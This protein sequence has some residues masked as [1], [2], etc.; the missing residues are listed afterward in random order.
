MPLPDW[1]L[2]AQERDNPDS[3]IPTW[4][5]GNA[6][7]PLIHGKAYFDRLVTEVE[8]LQEGDHLFFTDWRGD[9]DERM[10]DDGPTIV[11]LFGAAAKRG[12]VVKG[13]LWRSHVDKLAYSEEENRNL[14]DEIEAAGGEVLLD[15]RVRRGGSHHQKLVILRHPGQPERDIAFA[16]GIDLC[17]SRRDDERHLGDP[18]AVAMAKAYGKTPPWHDVQLALRG[19]VVGAL[20]LTFRERWNDPTP[21]DQNGPISTVTDKLKGADLRAD[22]LPEQPPDPPECGPLAIQVLRTYPAMRPPYKFASNGEQTIARGY[23]KAIKRA[24]KLIYLEDQ[25][26]WSAEVAQLFADA[27]TDNPELHLIAVVPRHPDVDGRFALPPN[28]VGREQAIQLCRMAA[29]DR[30][31]VLDLENS[32][33]TPIYVHAKVCVIDDVW[34]S[35]GSDNFNRRSWTHDSELSN[36][37]FDDTLDE[38]EPRDPAGL[39]DGARRFPRDLRLAL[40]REHLG[41]ESDEDLVD[42]VSVVRVMTSTADRLKQWHDEGG[43][44]P[45]PPGQIMP[46]ETSKLP[47]Y[48]RIWAVPAYRLMYDPDGRSLSDRRAGRW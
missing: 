19:P 9:P 23:T 5:A 33:S 6:A 35:V 13:L 40:T 48:Q 36:A 22:R 2:S 38:R 29:P 24:R 1:F 34:C 18:Q 21:L 39:G 27:L 12:V 3:S 42:P 46:H 47:W 14:G 28:E 37:I 25:Y 15:Q 4:V 16:G 41:R 43:K 45:R 32:E 20:D 30:V 44:G 11:E 17:H 8:S 31:H 7:E 10:R 26:L